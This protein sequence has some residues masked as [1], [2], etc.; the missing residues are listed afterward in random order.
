MQGKHYVEKIRYFTNFIGFKEA[1]DTLVQKLIEKDT[2]KI[3]SV[4]PSDVSTLPIDVK[5]VENQ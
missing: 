1:N 4:F 2:K 5:K 3:Q